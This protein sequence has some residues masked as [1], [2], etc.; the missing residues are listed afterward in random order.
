MQSLSTAN[1]VLFTFIHFY[2]LGNIGNKENYRFDYALLSNNIHCPKVVSNKF[3][4]FCL[5][6][7]KYAPELMYYVV[8][9]FNIDLFL[10]IDIN[11]LNVHSIHQY[12]T[13]KF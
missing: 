13:L 3:L 12:N 6:P 7:H 11:S 2:E 10:Y 5:L 8:Q 1:Y 9:D 4:S